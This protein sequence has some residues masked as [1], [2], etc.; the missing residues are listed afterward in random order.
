MNKFP[1]VY[2]EDNLI[3]NTLGECWALYK[4]KNFDY[5]FCTTDKKFEIL[6]NLT[7]FLVNTYTR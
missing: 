4:V 1:I 6:S 7:R 5:D 2:F 3:F